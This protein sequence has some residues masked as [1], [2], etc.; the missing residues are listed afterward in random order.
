MRIAAGILMIITAIVLLAVVAVSSA[1]LGGWETYGNLTDVLYLVFQLAWVGFIIAGGVFCLQRKHWGL[2][3]T[4][5]LLL[6]LFLI[7]SFFF[8]PSP[9]FLYPLGILPIIF[10]CLRKRQWQEI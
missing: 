9:L 1:A 2:C 8:F 4:S 7:L 10:V 3:F 6:A 5:S